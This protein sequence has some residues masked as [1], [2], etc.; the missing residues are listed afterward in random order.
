MKK[1]LFFLFLFLVNL[2]TS[3]DISTLSNYEEIK[4]T[5]LDGLMEID[6]TNNIVKGELHST[7]KAY[8]SGEYIILDCYTIQINEVKDES[9][10]EDLEF[11]VEEV[12]EKD[13][14]G[15]ALKISR[16]FK[17]NDEF[18]I[19]I[20]YETTEDSGSAQFLTP[21]QTE[22][23]KYPYAFT[24]SEMILGRQLLPI[25]DT[26]AI[27]M[28]VNMG[29]KVMKP[30]V[31]LFPG[32][33]HSTVEDGDSQIFYYNQTIPIPSYLISFAAGDI[34]SKK[35][36]EN[37]TIYTEQ[38]ML[39]AAV[40]EFEDIPQ[41]LE[42]CTKYMGEYMWPDYS[43]IIL[44]KSFP[45]SGMENPTL[46]FI[47][48]S[49]VA[50]DKSIVDIAVHEM[51][52]SWS[53]NLVTNENWSDFWLNEGITMFLQRKMV[54]MWKGEDYAKLDAILGLS[55]IA[56]CVDDF[57]EDSSYTSLH[58]DLSDVS[59]DDVFSD[60][61]YEKG[62]N[63]VYYIESV[64]NDNTEGI[65]Y[66]QKFFEQYFIDFRYKSLNLDEFKSYFIS[67]V[68]TNIPDQAEEMLAKINWDE[69]IYGTGN[70]PFEND[71]SNVYQEAA[72]KLLEKF[73]NEELDESFE[74]E[75]NSW[76]TL[77]KTYFVIALDENGEELTDAQHKFLG[78]NLNLKNRQNMLI[79]VNYFYTILEL[80]HEFLEGEEETLIEFL[81]ETGQIDYTRGLYELYY[82][83]NK[84]GA[85]ELYKSLEILYHIWAIDDVKEEYETAENEFIYL[86]L[87]KFKDEKC[88]T[89]KI[90]DKIPLEVK[91]YNES[92]GTVVIEENAYLVNKKD[93]TE[94]PANCT[95]NGEENY[96]Q[97]KQDLVKGEEY[98]LFISKSI[99]TSD[100]AVPNAKSS[101]NLKICGDEKPKEEEK[102]EEGGHTVL[103]I[104]IVVVVVVIIIALIL[105]KVFL[106]MK[107]N[108][109]TDLTTTKQQEGEKINELMPTQETAEA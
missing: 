47:A 20:N 25:Q 73:Y 71:F 42:N 68:E 52:H 88:I 33:R 46:N 66:M 49:L 57:G 106:N 103:I 87:E 31:A 59:P 78:D 82:M 98:Y 77:P 102:E 108:K 109:G 55:Y 2:I 92:L 75:F 11:K 96:C 15:T 26:P 37:I 79:S 13:F 30:L 99:H 58:P 19:Y 21:E 70:C 93:K 6:F 95:I 38:E 1:T 54:G 104:V 56:Y 69:W 80:T 74:K 5:H 9:T 39:D 14:L 91:G 83:R 17:E 22:G 41:F 72:D 63:F 76:P 105:L 43:M 61:P 27:K 67:F 10:G 84:T 62:F 81:K 65:D 24:Q 29:L 64:I 40:K 48:P 100:Y 50:G 97:A 16:P 3:K 12:A 89:Y 60:I 85:L 35:L 94:V 7:F 18:T 86:Y 23:K 45:V 51:I 32:V 101:N 90:G 107:K 4:E 34:K 36:S 8:A 44:P 28:T 53:G